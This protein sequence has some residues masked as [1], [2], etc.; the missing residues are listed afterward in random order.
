MK[1]KKKI[2]HHR[3]KARERRRRRRPAQLPQKVQHYEIVKH[4]R[5]HVPTAEE[6]ADIREICAKGTT[7]LEFKIFM[8]VCQKTKLDPFLKQIYCIMWPVKGGGHDMVIITGIGGYRKIA[9][10]DY[11]NDYAGASSAV[12][13]WFDPPVFTPAGRRVPE[14]ATVKILGKT[15]PAT[16]AT[17]WWEELAPAD[18]T[19]KRADFWNRMPKNQLEKCAEAKGLRKRFPGLGNIFTSEE[20][21]ARLMDLTPEGRQISVDG[22]APQSR[23]TVDS[24]AAAK[25]AQQKILDAKLNHAHPPGSAAAQNAENALRRVEEEDARLAAAKNV[26]PKSA[27]QEAKA[28]KQGGTGKERGGARHGIPAGAVP[29]TGTIHTVIHAETSKQHVPFIKIQLNRDWFTIWSKII[30]QAFPKGREMGMIGNV[31]ECFTK[32]TGDGVPDIVGLKR[33]GDQYFE[34]DGRTP[35]PREPGAEG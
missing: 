22:V 14:S 2:K 30:Q 17:V 19:E 16:E 10:A 29:L 21:E 20:V 7:E 15:G 5:P 12:F 32:K 4:G 24:Y 33:I 25:A 23:Q 13:T 6:L 18:L 27:K 26:T 11:P 28:E 1:T 9:A 31:V 8:Q 35:I 3:P 34:P